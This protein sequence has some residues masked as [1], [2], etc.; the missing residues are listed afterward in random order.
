[1]K[2]GPEYLIISRSSLVSVLHFGI[3]NFIFFLYFLRLI[4]MKKKNEALLH[5]SQTLAQL[6]Y[7]V[8]NP[9]V[10]FKKTQLPS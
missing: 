9:F 8:F 7:D 10:D 6:F 1:M 5:F 2:I 4:Q 3:F